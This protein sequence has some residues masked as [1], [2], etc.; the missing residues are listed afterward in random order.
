MATI[1]R[2]LVL[3]DTSNN[4]VLANLTV[5]VTDA[6]GSVRLA[7]TNSGITQDGNKFSR[8]LDYDTTW[9]YTGVIDWLY[10]GVVIASEVYDIPG[11]GVVKYV[12]GNARTVEYFLQGGFNKTVRTVNSFTVYS[13]DDITVLVAATLTQN[14]SLDPIASVAP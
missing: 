12:I 14:G 2:L 1:P 5:R 8:E 6:T 11:L 10:N 3:N 9:L 7:A 13:T 4:L